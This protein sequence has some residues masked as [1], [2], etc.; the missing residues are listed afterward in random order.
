MRSRLPGGSANL[1]IASASLLTLALAS[2]PALA[3]DAN[4]APAQATSSDGQAQDDAIVVT[5]S[6]VAKEG[7]TAPTP[8]T[9][10]GEA[11]VQHQAAVRVTDVLNTLP[12]L[13]QTSSPSTVSQQQGGNYVQLRGLGSVRTLVLVNNRRFVSTTVNNLVDVNLIPTSLIDRIEVV[14]GGASAAWGSDAVAGVSNFILKKDVKGLVGSAQYG[15]STHGDSREYALSLATGMD[16]GG[17]RGHVQLAGEYSK[18]YDYLFGT[19]RDWASRNWGYVVG[20]TAT[21]GVGA[22]RYLRSGLTSPILAPGGTVI[23]GSGGLL[24][25]GNTLRGIQFGANGAIL[26]FAYGT[27]GLGNTI[28][29]NANLQVGGQGSVVGSRQAMNSPLERYTLFGTV[30]YE[31]SD[32]VRFFAEASWGRSKSATDALDV[33]SPN[34]GLGINILTTNPYV[35]AALL[36]I[37]PVGTTSYNIGRVNSELGR[38]ILT[39]DNKTGRFVAGF[40]G[41]FG[42]G[43]KWNVYAGYGRSNNHSEIRNHLISANWRA[44]QDAVAGPNNTI[45]CRI[46]STNP[47]D[48]AIT[49]AAGYAGA[50]ASAGCVPVN[51]FGTNTITP[52]AAAYV[53]GTQ[54]FDF[55]TG[56]TIAGASLSGEPFST[57]A[58]PVAISTGLEYRRE[59]LV[60][61]SD[62]IS[63]RSTVTFPAGGF[64]FG[65]PKPINGH[66]NVKEGFFEA[67]VPLL[68]ANGRDAIAL[69]GAVRLTD[70]STSGTVTTWKL[71]GTIEPLPGLMFRATRSRDIRAPNNNELFL[72]TQTFVE[73]VT[74]FGNGNAPVQA[75]RLVQ[76][77][78]ALKPEKADTTTIG[79]T[80]Q[81]EVIPGL[82]VALDYYDIRVKGVIGSLTAQ[83]ILNFCYGQGGFT[84]DAS[85]CNFVNRNPDGSLKNVVATNFNLQGL[86]TDG[87]DFELAY[88]RPLGNGRIAV[89]FLA[90]YLHSLVIDQGTGLANAVIDR[91]GEAAQNGFNGVPN[92][93]PKWRHTFNVDYSSGPLDVFAQ[94]RLVGSGVY[95]VTL[96]STTPGL[97]T[98]IEDNRIPA[99]SYFDL[100]VSY[101]LIDNGDRKLELFLR[102]DNIL[103][104][105]PPIV[106]QGGINPIANSG[107]FYDLVGRRITGGI[108]FKY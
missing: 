14:T 44:A 28:E 107:S 11:L 85:Y 59:S 60:G 29:N 98:Y 89:R 82:R 58:G 15:Q 39:G 30:D 92:G 43:W 61:D 81:P 102:G 86:K 5:G 90:N 71:G 36:A 70:Y 104:K 77:N 106:I 100:A 2:A 48:I 34:A 37:T 42:A 56:Q 75:I 4:S 31:V 95:D 38:T 88:S 21:A 54:V 3:A 93:S 17:G 74:D 33:F 27:D 99:V 22:G 12:S 7:F 16:F 96:Q 72:S 76:G 67:A 46:N 6:R 55:H 41:S 91:A 103:D 50:G 69:N 78:P 24:P 80:L 65:N 53:M 35:P 87:L 105:D 19:S 10:V 94:W 83:Q 66:Y 68:E 26:P 101:K 45:I 47:A 84:K 18:S 51:P 9:V 52:Q 57:W 49:S 40:D 63:K 25:V 64:N 23:S 32:N 62:P 13:R 20:P 8:V 1:L 79:V 97:N 73:N 108:R